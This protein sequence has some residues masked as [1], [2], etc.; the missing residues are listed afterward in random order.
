MAEDRESVI[1]ESANESDSFSS[2][3]P[4]WAEEEDQ[5]DVRETVLDLDGNPADVLVPIKF[6]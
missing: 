1:Q 6:I 5:G 3:G 2:G 4:I